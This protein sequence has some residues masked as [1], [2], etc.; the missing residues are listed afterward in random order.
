MEGLKT[1]YTET[2]LIATVSTFYNAPVDLDKAIK[3]FEIEYG[4][5]PEIIEN[6]V[7]EYVT[8]EWCREQGY[9]RFINSKAITFMKELQESGVTNMLESTPYIMNAL[10]YDKKMAKE[11]LITYITDYEKFYHPENLI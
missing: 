7:V 10:G 6:E 2:E 4:F 9:P 1:A 8:D 5:I 3:I 11:L